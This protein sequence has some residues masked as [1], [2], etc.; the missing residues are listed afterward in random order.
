VNKEMII[1]KGTRVKLYTYEMK[2]GMIIFEETILKNDKKGVMLN[3]EKGIFILLDG[4]GN[5]IMIS[6]NPQIKEIREYVYITPP[7]EVAYL[8]PPPPPPRPRVVYLPPPIYYYP[9]PSLYLFFHFHEERHY[10][11]P[12]VRTLPP[13]IP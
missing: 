12:N 1:K 5:L 7:P 10:I 8:I 13:Y 9:D 11:P 3:C 2:K 4:C 6:E